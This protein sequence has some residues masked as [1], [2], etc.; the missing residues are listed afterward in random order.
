M[1]T[2]KMITY[3]G[4]AGTIEVEDFEVNKVRALS[5]S[6][7]IG[8]VMTELTRSLENSLKALNAQLADMAAR[9]GSLVRAKEQV[10]NQLRQDLQLAQ[11]HT[12]SE[13]TA[14]HYTQIHALQAKEAEITHALYKAEVEL[15]QVLENC[16]GERWYLLNNAAKGDKG[17][18][19]KI[20]DIEWY[21]W[22]NIVLAQ[23][24]EW[25]NNFA[26]D[27]IA[28][29]KRHLI[30]AAGTLE[31]ARAQLA[32][33]KARL[34]KHQEAQSA[35]FSSGTGRPPAERPQPTPKEQAAINRGLA[36]INRYMG[37][38]YGGVS[39]EPEASPAQSRPQTQPDPAATPPQYLTGGRR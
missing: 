23:I 14:G 8:E 32:S 18:G 5:Q 21:D 31:Y 25:S 38:N 6:K 4:Q 26:P 17:S 30:E 34:E 13:I 3:A 10:V 9:H 7:P 27:L 24:L 33:A 20:E 36:E 11:Q 35:K 16:S 2:I 39:I 29:S 19:A 1:A 28:I 12:Q 22:R 37:R 15:A